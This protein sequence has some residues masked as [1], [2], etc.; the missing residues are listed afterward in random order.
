MLWLLPPQEGLDDEHAAAAARAGMLW[1]FRLFGLSACRSLGVGR[2]D[3]VDRDEWH[4]EQLADTGDIL[5]AGLA[6]EQTVVA[7]AMKALWQYMH[8]EAADELGGIERHHL[9]SPGAFAAVILPLEGDAVVIER[10]QAAVGD[11]DAVGVAR[12]IAQ[13]F[14]WSPE[15]S[16]AVDHPFAVAQGR[17]IGGEGSRIGERGV[18]AEEL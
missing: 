18:L 12:E 15:R 1:C 8:Q 6:G 17:Q 14:F 7:D 10:D 2:L 13:H 5:G 9:V 4:C 3:G 16:F 11:G